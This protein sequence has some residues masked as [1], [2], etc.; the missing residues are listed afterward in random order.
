MSRPLSRL[1]PHAPHGAVTG[2]ALRGW[3]VW[4]LMAAL[5]FASTLGLVHRTVHG[6]PAAA[7]AQAAAASFDGAA[8]VP[9]AKAVA[10]PSAPASALAALFGLHSA[11]HAECR[12]YDQLAHGAAVPSV[13]PVVLPV[14]LPPARFVYCLGEALARW[15]ALFDARGPPLS[16]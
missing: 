2:A 1:A 15:V 4:A 12:L 16:R 7:S 13:P 9:G 11:G 3:M 5:C 14:V 10:T 6:L 8:A